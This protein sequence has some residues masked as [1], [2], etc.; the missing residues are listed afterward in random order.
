MKILYPSSVAS[1]GKLNNISVSNKKSQ[2]SNSSPLQQS[3]KALVY[4]KTYLGG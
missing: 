1:Y 2:K 4:T 3:E